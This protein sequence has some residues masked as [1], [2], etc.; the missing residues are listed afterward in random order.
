VTDASDAE[1]LMRKLVKFV[2]EKS[3]IFEKDGRYFGHTHSGGILTAAAGIARWAVHTENAELLQQMKKVF[4]WTMMYSSSWGWVPDGLGMPNGS[5]ETC[6]ITDAIHLGLIVAQYVD[7]SYYEV[8][9]R[10]AGNQLMENQFKRTETSDD[11]LGLERNSAIAKAFYGSWASWSFPN[12]LD[13]GLAM[14]EGC[15]LG[16]GMRGCFLVWDNIITKKQGTVS[17]NMALSRNSPWVEVV[18]YQP[19]QGRVDLIVHD[20]PKLLVRIPSWVRQSELTV[21]INDKAQPFNFT[22]QKYIV[23]NG[24]KKD[25][26]ITVAYPLERVETCE[27][28]NGTDYRVQWR[29]DTVTH[30][31]P[32]GLIVPIFERDWMET[33]EVPMAENQPYANQLGGPVHW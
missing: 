23:F 14:I 6:S 21:T 27:N 30:I 15:C 1:D 18:S 26:V 24:L 10:I 12:S 2:V 17:V 31:S 16:S 4:D 29:G 3:G 5:S 20:A 11:I 13:N 33:D 8:V 7:P 22:D 19:Y 9:E 28:V 25:D 32:K